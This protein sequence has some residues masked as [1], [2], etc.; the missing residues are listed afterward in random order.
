MGTCP[1]TDK[2]KLRQTV[3]LPSNVNVNVRRSSYTVVVL[4]KT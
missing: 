3:K 1:D 2:I 4:G